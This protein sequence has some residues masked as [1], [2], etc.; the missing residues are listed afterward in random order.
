VIRKLSLPLSQKNEISKFSQVGR[1]ST[2]SNICHTSVQTAY[3]ALAERRSVKKQVIAPGDGEAMPL[4]PPMA[5]RLAGL[6]SAHLWWPAAAA[7]LFSGTVHTSN[8]Q[9]YM[10][11]Y[12]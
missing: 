3:T 10:K 7:M 11:H 5:V 1:M 2:D 9:H 12:M 8:T 6:Q 4:P